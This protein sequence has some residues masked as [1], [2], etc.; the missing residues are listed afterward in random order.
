MLF[1][2][3]LY[4]KPDVFF[5]SESGESLFHF[6]GGFVGESEGGNLRR[7]DALVEQGGNAMGNDAGLSLPGPARTRSGPSTNCTACRCGSFKPSSKCLGI[8]FT[9]T[10]IA[11]RKRNRKIANQSPPHKQG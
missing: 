1:V 7:T 10:I 4:H 8:F 2:L 11:Y 9:P 3:K 6:V 5:G